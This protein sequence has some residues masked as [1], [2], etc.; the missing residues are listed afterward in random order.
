MPRL[1]A[2]DIGTNTLLLCVAEIAPEGLRPLVERSII[3]RLGEGLEA[4]GTLRPAAIERGLGALER[5][6]EEAR[7]AGA[8]RVKAV[9]TAALREA[10]DADRFLEEA[11]ARF[12]I[13][14]EVLSGEE[15][16]RLAFEAVARTL[17]EGGEVAAGSLMVMDIGGGSTEFV[18]GE[19]REVRS[20][21]SLR[22]GAVRA[23]ERFLPDDPV[24]PG[25]VEALTR[26]LRGVLAG[27]P[28]AP[29]G[30]LEMV[31]VAGTNTTLAA[32]KLGLTAYD[33]G[34]IRRTRISLEDLERLIE[35][36]EA[37]S[38]AE[39]RRLPGL[40]PG[41]A[42]VILAGAVIAREGMIRYRRETMAV[43]DRGLRHGVLHRMAEN[44][45]H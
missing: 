27:L 19:G 34:A 1:A 33:A 40:E 2:I 3:A 45:K 39:R 23:T 10:R 5:H 16:A 26:H 38:V 30:A 13:E 15:E 35:T 22:V 4:S 8:V 25:Q 9:G 28:D 41:R 17:E 31:G 20:V 43:S 11:K 6:L 32:M 29:G 7:A 24:R 18:L 37:R 12:G 14:I 42:D 36:L 44:G 21:H